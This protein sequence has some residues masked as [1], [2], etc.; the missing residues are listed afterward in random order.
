M[1]MGKVSAWKYLR[2]LTYE[3][4]RSKHFLA[5]DRWPYLFL[6]TLPQSGQRDDQSAR[7]NREMPPHFSDSLYYSRSPVE[8]HGASRQRTARV[9]VVCA[10]SDPDARDDTGKADGC[11]CFGQE[12]V[13]A[14][15]IGG[16][17]SQAAR[18]RHIRD[19][20]YRSC[21]LHM[22]AGSAG[23]GAVIAIWLISKALGCL[24]CL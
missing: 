2:A 11:A 13:I 17:E 23:S 10:A 8:A 3:L 14:S 16:L 1:C 9:I 22:Q 18:C 15:R 5:L 19:T 21:M 6:S 24:S 4:P 20:A 12:S 7:N